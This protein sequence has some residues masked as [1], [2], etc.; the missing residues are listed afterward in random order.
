MWTPIKQNSPEKNGIYWVTFGVYEDDKLIDRGKEIV[1]Y[2]DNI[3]YNDLT[4]DRYEF[5]DDIIKVIAW[6]EFYEPKTYEGE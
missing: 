1:Y 6:L 2:K 4:E 5:E 3:W